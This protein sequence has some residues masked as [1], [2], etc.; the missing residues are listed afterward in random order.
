LTTSSSDATLEVWVA[1]LWFWH[2]TRDND[3][4]LDRRGAHGNDTNI[5]RTCSWR[6][7]QFAT[8]AVNSSSAGWGVS[9]CTSGSVASFSRRFWY[10]AM[11]VAA[12]TR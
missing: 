9:N 4:P 6:A 12:Q 10:A 11:S 1:P 8:N 7:L 5:G 2:P 3:D